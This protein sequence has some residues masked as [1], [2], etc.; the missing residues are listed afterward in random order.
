MHSDPRSRGTKTKTT[1]E[2]PQA[3]STPDCR[4][5]LVSC[6]LL[7]YL[8]IIVNLIE[9]E[10]SERSTSYLSPDPSTFNIFQYL[11]LIISAY[12]LFPLYCFSVSQSC[13]ILWDPTDCS[14]PGFPV[15]PCSRS[16]LKL[17]SIESGM[18]SNHLILYHPLFLLPSIFFSIR[19]FSKESALRIMWPK[20]W[21]FSFSISP[22]NQ[23]S[24]LISFRIDWFALLAVQGTCNS[25]LQHHSLKASILTVYIHVV[26]CVH[27]CTCP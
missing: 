2:L 14:T 7:F 22:S 27:G 12:L 19:V 4:A 20:Y 1:S 10:I 5:S 9:L 26:E 18:P 25:L 17:V 21:S 23:Y 11:F 24:G 3:P 15:P 13:S 6:L 16:W 8:T